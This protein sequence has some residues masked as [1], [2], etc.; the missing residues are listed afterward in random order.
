MAKATTSLVP[1]YIMTVRGELALHAVS[2]DLRVAHVPSGTVRGPNINGRLIGPNAD[3]LRARP[4]GFAR[5]DV[6]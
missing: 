5:L 2:D 1:D 3:W 4:G 6:H